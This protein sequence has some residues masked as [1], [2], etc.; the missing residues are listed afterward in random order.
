MPPPSPNCG[1][2]HTVF[3]RK[4]GSEAH[5]P[6]GRAPFWAQPMARWLQ[7]PQPTVPGHGLGHGTGAAPETPAH[8][9]RPRHGSGSRAPSP[10]SQ[11][12]GLGH[13]AGRAPEPPAHCPRSRPGTQPGSSSRAPSPLSQATAWDTA[14]DGHRSG[15]SEQ[16]Q[17]S[18][19]GLQSRRAL[20]GD[21][22]FP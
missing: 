21:Q 19:E 5:K 7:S 9:P 11:G 2:R 14:R 17:R 12:H 16:E 13:G 4:L 20:T 3:S 15:A 18:S 10:L 6:G 8:C 22:P 1:I